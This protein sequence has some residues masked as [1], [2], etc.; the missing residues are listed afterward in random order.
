MYFALLTQCCNT[1]WY[2]L[3]QIARHK[4]FL[5]LH[6]V[7]THIQCSMWGIFILAFILPHP[8]ARREL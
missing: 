3:N 8:S 5:Y 4:A 1:A 6:L 2:R 7:C